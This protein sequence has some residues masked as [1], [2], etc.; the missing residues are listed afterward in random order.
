MGRDIMERDGHTMEAGPSARERVTTLILLAVFCAFGL[1]DH[2][3]WSANDTR[4]G[5]MIAEMARGGSW[6][7]PHLNGVPY[8]EKPPLLHW[9]GAVFC[10]L[11]GTVNEGLV[12]L[13][14]ALFG[15]G[16]LL[17]I[18]RFGCELG[19]ERAGLIAASLCATTQLMFEYSRIVLTDVALTFMVLLS[20]WLFWRAYTATTGR[21]GWYAAMLIVTALSFYAKGL[22]GPGFVW[23]AVGSLWR[24]AWRLL[25]SL[26]LAFLPI[27]ALLLA[28]WVLGL[29]H[30]GGRDYLVGIF[31]D[32]QFG[33]FLNF[34]DPTLPHD[35]FR[36]HKEPLYYYL[37]STPL[38]L[39][40]WTLLVLA[41]LWRWFQPGTAY[42]GDLPLAGVL[43]V[44]SAKTACY[45]LPLFPLLLLMTGLW[46]EDR[47]RSNDARRGERAALAITSAAL[48]AILLL[49]PLGVLAANGWRWT[50]G[51]RTAWPGPALAIYSVAMAAL[52]LGVTLAFL[53]RFLRR[54][55][56]GAAPELAWHGPMMVVV[57]LILTVA[58]VL[59]V[60]DRAKTYQPVAEFAQQ[61]VGRW[62]RIA[63]AHDIGIGVDERDT[64]ALTF[65]LGRPIDPLPLDTHMADYLFVNRRP[66]VVV[67]RAD[68]LNKARELLA[69]HAVQFIQTPHV[70][71]KARGFW[72]ALP[73]RGR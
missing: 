43:H 11:F 24:R 9:T 35:P 68:T 17:L 3:L 59:P 5:A 62:G 1:F 63:L 65:Y 32:N 72:L 55:R 18:W 46:L 60:L 15:F 16:S 47:L 52:A 50:W 67:V 48:G 38:R 71:Y 54:W 58:A 44:S 64:G 6:T 19:R 8:L 41:A 7:L 70:G 10:R 27:L 49:A 40:P 34:S 21:R 2:G 12:R 66:G 30:E 56:T 57:S 31:W 23:V 51:A 4:E 36:V 69:G 73:I 33:R 28:P 29:W 42:R 14:S 39:L 53:L 61:Q 37:K 20:L 26:A 13:P 45:A 25:F 22:L